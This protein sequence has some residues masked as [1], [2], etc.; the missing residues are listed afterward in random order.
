MY[1]NENVDIESKSDT[2]RNK[3]KYYGNNTHYNTSNIR[4]DYTVVGP[5]FNIWIPQ[6]QVGECS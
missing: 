2:C 3:D 6:R 4:D 1:N 5:I